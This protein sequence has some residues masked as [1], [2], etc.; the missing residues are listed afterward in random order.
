MIDTFLPP[1]RFN[2]DHINQTI[3]RAL[4][5]AGLDT[6]TG[7]MHGVRE[8]IRRALESGNRPSVVLHDMPQL[9]VLEPTGDP[10]SPLDRGD[11]SQPALDGTLS[12]PGR[13]IRGEFSNQAGT[14]AYKLYMP[15]QTSESL[16]PLIVMLHGCTQ[17]ADDFARG[18]QM[19]SL[20]EDNGF[21]VL[22]PEQAASGNASKCW[23]WFQPQD[24]QR[25]KGEP[26]LIAGMVREVAHAHGVD[27]RRVFVAGLSAGAAMA[28]V[29]GETYPDIFA[30]VGA[31][32]GLPF[33]S[34]HDIPSAMAAMKGGR[35]R[36][37]VRLSGAPTARRSCRQPVPTIVFHGDRDHTVQH[38]NGAAILQ[39]A[40]DAYR[41]GGA[42]NNDTLSTITDQG[43]AAGGRKFS[44]SLHAAADGRPQL[45]LWTL[46]G[47]GH[48]WSGGDSSGTYTDG[49]GPDASTEMVRFFLA[50]SR[51]GSA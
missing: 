8:T 39:Q 10:A 38:S 4:A 42:A 35:G 6:S 40:S 21:L 46:H 26:S 28:V 23:N 22:Y 18:T 16:R 33:A 7:P 34:A 13:F 37:S 19:N 49:S 29:L 3:Q 27:E 31:H 36:G 50:Q 43:V 24:Q 25:D 9:E 15:R 30:A 1:T 47:A 51:A 41:T 45:E 11:G 2:A 44:R 12:L 17:S 20:A 14:R 48:A 32:S 5:S